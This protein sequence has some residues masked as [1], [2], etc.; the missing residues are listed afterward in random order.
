MFR[1]LTS[2]RATIQTGLERRAMDQ[3]VM[4]IAE[5]ITDPAK[6]KQLRVVA[7]MKPLEKRAIAL[8]SILTI[9][10]TGRT[11]SGADTQLPL[12]SGPQ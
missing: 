4:A 11:F 1:A 6:R 12:E 5:A 10:A 3:N 2:P 8:V 7:H 9:P